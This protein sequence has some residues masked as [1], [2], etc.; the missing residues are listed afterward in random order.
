MKFTQLQNQAR[1]NVKSMLLFYIL[2]TAKLV[3]VRVLLI[4]HLPG[5]GLGRNQ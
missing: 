2:D 4:L 1:E 3:H 5:R